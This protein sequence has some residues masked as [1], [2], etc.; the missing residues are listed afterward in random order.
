MLKY[1]LKHLP[2]KTL[3][4]VFCGLLLVPKFG[5]CQP[6]FDVAGVQYW[7]SPTNLSPDSVGESYFSFSTSVPLRLSSQYTL[8]PGVS[9]EYRELLNADQGSYEYLSGL[10]VT[11]GLVRYSKYSVHSISATLINRMSVVGDWNLD[12]SWQ[13]GGALVASR[14]FSPRFTGRIGLYYNTE[15]FGA[16]FLPLVGCDWRISDK[17]RL[18]GLLPSNLRLQHRISDRANAGISFRSFTNSFRSDS[19]GYVKILDNHLFTY[20]DF[21][22]FNRIVGVVEVG[23]SAMREVYFVESGGI[24]SIESQGVLFKTGLFYRVPLP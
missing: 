9:M 19:E 11:F 1:S 8:L 3:T 18:F 14:K 2:T 13:L 21:K 24:G 22:I 15:F 20:V 23:Y 5:L 10:T 17:W 4:L 12:D 16:Y 6:Y 7:Q